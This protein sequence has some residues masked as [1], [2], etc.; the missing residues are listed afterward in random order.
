MDTETICRDIYR[1]TRAFYAATKIALGSAD[2]GFRILYGPP[3]VNAP[4]I[5]V[6]YQPGGFLVDALPGEHDTWPTDFDYTYET[7]PLARYA[8]ET[9]GVPVLKQCTALNYIFFR[10]PRIA[11]WRRVPKG[12][13]DEIERFCRARAERIVRVL[14]PQRIVVVGMDTFYALTNGGDI[15]LKSDQRV[16]VRTDF[17]WGVPA[18][19]II[20]LS[21]ARISRVDRDKLATY[22]AAL[23]NR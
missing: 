8:R 3:I 9:W 17:L 1:E 14:A 10:A 4:Y 23:P 5:F 18:H 6:G 21:G 2:Q 12:L 20:H 7:W 13:R 16:L 11:A 22:F 19:G 15:S